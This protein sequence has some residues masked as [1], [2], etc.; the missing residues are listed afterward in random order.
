MGHYLPQRR[1]KREKLKSA[2][3]SEGAVHR[4]H[5][6]SRSSYWYFLAFVSRVRSHGRVKLVEVESPHDLR[7]LCLYWISRR[8]TAFIRR[9]GI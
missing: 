4:R 6:S 5:E 1:N 9:T 2:K 3:Y 7:L 8:S